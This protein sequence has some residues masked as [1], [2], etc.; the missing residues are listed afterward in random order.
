MKRYLKV[1]SS[2]ILLLMEKMNKHRFHHL[3][4]Y[5]WLKIVRS[6]QWKIEQLALIFI[7]IFNCTFPCHA[8]LYSI[9]LLYFVV[10]CVRGLTHNIVITLFFINDSCIEDVENGVRAHECD[11]LRV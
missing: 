1:K 8:H 2:T 3:D 10:A 11:S 6:G 5:S 7:L 4:E 9:V